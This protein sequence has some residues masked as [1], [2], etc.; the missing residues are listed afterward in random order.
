MKSKNFS[1][2][3]SIALVAMYAS[4]VFATKTMIAFIPNV[5]VTTLL[6][7]FSVII[8]NYWKA[9][10]ITIVF[11]TLDVLM[12]GFGTW[13]ITYLILWPTLITMIFI[14]RKTKTLNWFTFVLINTL[15]G[16]MF[17]TLDATVN[18]I[19]FDWS[20]FYAYWIKGLIF[21]VIHGCSNFLVAYFLYK[22]IYNVY[23]ND[24][25]RY[26]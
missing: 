12:W 23:R 5:E 26:L 13:Y 21:D 1:H 17:G 3:Y 24:L 7:S 9:L 6:L 15:F 16:F 14:L 25:A 10:L 19:F 2:A 11:C 4:M 8:F 18:L 22:P 20:V